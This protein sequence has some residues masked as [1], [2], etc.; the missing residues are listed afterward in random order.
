MLNCFDS[1][2]WP[3]ARPEAEADTRRRPSVDVAARLR[4]MW[5]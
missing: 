1:R 5:S 2:A 3:T 4:R